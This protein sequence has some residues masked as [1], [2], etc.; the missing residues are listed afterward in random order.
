MHGRVSPSCG[1]RKMNKAG[2]TNATRAA[3]EAERPKTPM[4]TKKK[5]TPS[6]VATVAPTEFQTEIRPVFIRRSA[7]KGSRSNRPAGATKRPPKTLQIGDRKLARP[8]DRV[9]V[10][11]NIAVVGTS[12]TH[13]KPLRQ[14]RL[15]S[16]L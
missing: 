14:R 15:S 4:M 2:A 1:R 10:A 5:A 16:N 13:G 3:I 9:I 11:V 7:W 12:A 6:I 8:R